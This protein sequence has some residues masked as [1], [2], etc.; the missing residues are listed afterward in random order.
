MLNFF[1]LLFSAVGEF[2]GFLKQNQLIEAGEIKAVAAQQKGEIRVVKEA[3]EARAEAAV[4][5]S[6]VPLDVGL[7]DDGFRRD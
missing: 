4:A 1:K 7:P 6:A 5:A 2:F 3:T